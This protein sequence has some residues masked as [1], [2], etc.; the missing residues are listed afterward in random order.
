MAEG[1]TTVGILTAFGVGYLMAAQ[2][3]KEGVN[4]VVAAAR[5]VKESDE[6]SY[7]IKALRAHAGEVFQELGK[8]ISGDSSGPLSITDLLERN[9]GL[10]AK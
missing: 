6:F 10:N 4:E 5:S 9:R 7:L 8:R 3:G 2:G 1:K